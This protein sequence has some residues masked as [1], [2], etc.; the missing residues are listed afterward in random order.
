MA[1][2]VGTQL[3]A[4]A[5]TSSAALV[6]E[7]KTSGLSSVTGVS[8]S[9]TAVV[10]APPPPLPSS[11]PSP[12]SSEESPLAAIAGAIIGIALIAPGAVLSIL[13]MFFKP[14]LRRKLVRYGFKRLANF[15]VPDVVGW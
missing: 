10:A 7:L 15:I 1:N 4:Y 8:L 9:K 12:P 14:Y 5:S 11:P 6:A 3:D 2:S 13:A